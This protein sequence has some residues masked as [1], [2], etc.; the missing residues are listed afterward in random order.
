MIFSDLVHHHTGFSAIRIV[1]SRSENGEQFARRATERAGVALQSAA[2]DPYGFLF[3]LG[4]RDD[5]AAVFVLK[6]D[7]DHD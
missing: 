4:E 7:V 1:H 2:R 5:L 3:R 6:F